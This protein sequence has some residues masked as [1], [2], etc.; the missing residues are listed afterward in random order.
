MTYIVLRP[1][2][3]HQVGQLL[4]DLVGHNA[5]YL[6]GAGFVAEDDTNVDEDSAKPVHKKRK[7][8]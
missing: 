5:D 2:A 1:F 7:D 8:Q 3:D 4:P 6:I